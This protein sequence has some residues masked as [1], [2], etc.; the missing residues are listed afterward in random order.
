VEA[1][2]SKEVYTTYEILPFKFIV[3]STIDPGTPL[4]Y[5]CD[6]TLLGIGKYGRP[7]LEIEGYSK[8]LGQTKQYGRV[9]ELKGFHQL[10]ELYK[11]YQENGFDLDKV[12]RENAS[13]LL[14]DWT[15]INL[16]G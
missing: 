11:Y 13:E 12:V 7:S 9:E 2:K 10:I 8:D 3:E 15:G 16:K 5:T 6:S 4:V 1:L 14:L